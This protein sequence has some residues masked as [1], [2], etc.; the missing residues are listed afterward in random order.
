MFKKGRKKKDISS[1]VWELDFIRGICILLVTLEHVAVFTHAIFPFWSYDTGNPI[2]SALLDFRE[3]E[4]NTPLR[5]I[6]LPGTV[7]MFFLISGIC[8]PFSR[9]NLKNA[10]KLTVAAALFTVF[11]VIIGPIVSYSPVWF[12]IFHCFALATLIMAL[13]MKV[14]SYFPKKLQR[15]LSIAFFLVLGMLIILL[16]IHHGMYWGEQ[17]F[18]WELSEIGYWNGTIVN[19]MFGWT[20]AMYDF[21]RGDYRPLF[22]FIG[23]MSIG[24]ALSKLLYNEKKSLIKPLKFMNYSP[25]NAAGRHTIAAYFLLPA[26]YLIFAAILSLVV[27]GKLLG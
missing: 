4:H 25:I 13:L 1:H 11:T 15:G 3:F 19:G 10:C 18:G 8:F 5:N 6:I 27:Y 12:G 21:S 7:T 2:I 17:L 20:E 16:D 23:Y 9:D 24:I 22:P 26:A 14:T